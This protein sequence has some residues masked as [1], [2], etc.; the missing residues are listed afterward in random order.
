MSATVNAS[1][2]V[3]AALAMAIIFLNAMILPA[4]ADFMP[5]DSR[6]VGSQALK[7]DNPRERA[8]L[9]RASS[10]VAPIPLAGVLSTRRK[11]SSSFGLTAS[12]RYAIMSFTS[13]L[14]KK[15]LPE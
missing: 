4:A 1:S 3:N 14:S 13:A 9:T 11:D 2:F 10:D 12:F 15:E 7:S 5:A 6:I 8:A